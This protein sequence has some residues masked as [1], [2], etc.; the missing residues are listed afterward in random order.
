MES[1]SS[2]A[3]LLRYL[4]LLTIMASLWPGAFAWLDFL[5]DDRSIWEDDNELTAL[6][7]IFSATPV[8]LLIIGFAWRKRV[9]A[10]VGM[11]V[12][13]VVAIWFSCYPSWV[14][15]Y[16]LGLGASSNA[17]VDYLEW[18]KIGVWVVML[19]LLWGFVVGLDIG[20]RVVVS[21]YKRRFVLTRSS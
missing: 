19:L 6:G 4:V 7:L 14:D 1:A 12:L 17:D 5:S 9:S 10:T 8:S 3:L 2:R 16:N 15:A 20:R 21:I 18:S 13:A 11:T